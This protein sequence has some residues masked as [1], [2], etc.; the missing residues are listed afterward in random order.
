M[1]WLQ[2]CL[3]ASLKLDNC[4]CGG[5]EH[6]SNSRADT[7]SIPRTLRN[8]NMLNIFPIYREQLPQSAYMAVSSQ[9]HPFIHTPQPQNTQ[10][11]P[12]NCFKHSLNPPEFQRRPWRHPRLLTKPGWR[13]Q[14]PWQRSLVPVQGLTKVQEPVLE[15]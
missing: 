4:C 12:Q 9:Q 2:Q 11:P 7:S 3:S 6:H 15:G 10:I 14:H 8:Y 5:K 1:L 13:N